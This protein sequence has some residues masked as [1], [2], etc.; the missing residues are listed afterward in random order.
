MLLTIFFLVVVAAIVGMY[1]HD[2]NEPDREKHFF[3]SWF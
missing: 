2:V 3:R 1:I